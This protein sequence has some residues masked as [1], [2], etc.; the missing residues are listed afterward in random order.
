MTEAACSAGATD[1]ALAWLDDHV[2]LETGVGVP[3]GVD[4]RR[5]APTLAR[6]EAQANRPGLEV[7]DL[8]L[9]NATPLIEV[10]PRIKREYWVNLYSDRYDSFCHKTRKAADANAISDERIACVKV[11]ID[12]E[13]GEGL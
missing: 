11:S 3:S 13:E 6:I 1:D 5:S 8:A 12:C 2:N 4:R 7:L 10:K 9:R